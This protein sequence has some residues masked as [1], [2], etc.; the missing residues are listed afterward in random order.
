[1]TGRK[2]TQKAQKTDGDSIL[3]LFSKMVSTKVFFCSIFF[4]ILAPLCGQPHPLS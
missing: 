3:S 1:M 2:E 4:A